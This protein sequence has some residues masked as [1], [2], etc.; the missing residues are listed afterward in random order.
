MVD[1]DKT[2]NVC[3][4][5]REDEPKV[6]GHWDSTINRCTKVEVTTNAEGDEV[7]IYPSRYPYCNLLGTA[8]QCSY[9]DGNGTE[10]RCILPDPFRHVC[11]RYTGQKWV[12]MRSPAQYDGTGDMLQA[13]DWSFDDI[14]GYNDGGCDG[15]GTDMEC[16]GYSPYHMGFGIIQPEGLPSNWLEFLE[17]P[18]EGYKTV[19]DLGY[20]LPILYVVLNV[21]AKLSRCHWWAGDIEEF[22]ID[23]DIGYVN[24][25]N[26]LCTCNDDNTTR[27]GE[28]HFDSSGRFIPPCNGAHD[29]CP[30]YT[31]ICW[32]HCIV[33]KMQTGDKILAEQILELRY[34]SKRET[35]TL[36]DYNELF[37]HPKIFSWTGPNG[38]HY[39]FTDAGI[40]DVDNTLID[41]MEV[42]QEDF[43]T[44]N[45]EYKK[46]P[47]SEGTPSQDGNMRFPTLVGSI[48][49]PYLKP[50]IRNSFDKDIYGNNLFEVTGLH[51]SSVLIYGDTFWYGSRTYAINLRDDDISKLIPS[52]IFEFEDMHE[53]EMT[54]STEGEEYFNEFYDQLDYIFT[55][56]ITYLPDKVFISEF[57]DN[58]SAFYIDFLANFG[59]NLVLVFN[60][61]SG[62]WEFD[63]M[64]FVKGLCGGVIKQHSFSIV[65]TDNKPAD[66]L[67]WY[68]RNFYSL[69]NENGAIDFEFQSF[70]PSIMVSGSAVDHVYNDHFT[71]VIA[72][73]PL[74]AAS[75]TTYHQSYR[76]FRVT[77]YE[78][79]II[80]KEHMKFL[81]SSGYVVVNV[82]D[83]DKKLSNVHRLWES[84]NGFYLLV[85]D[86]SGNSKRIKMEV[87]E[88][89]T[90]RLEVNQIVLKPENMNDFSQAC[91]AAIHTNKI[92][93]Y[94][95]R[96]FGETPD[97]E[98]YEDITEED[99]GSGANLVYWG[100]YQVLDYNEDTDLFTVSKFNSEPMFISVVYKG[101]NGRIKGVTRTKLLVWIKQPFCRDVEIYYKWAASYTKWLLKPTFNCLISKMDYIREERKTKTFA[102]PC[103]DHDLKV[104]AEPA[105][106]WY[107]YNAC[108]P[109]DR[110]EIITQFTEWD[111]S[112]IEQFD[113][114]SDDP[115]H[116]A[117]DMRMMG[118]FNSYAY[119]C[120]NHARLRN[121]N[122]D[123][124]YCNDIK[125][126]VDGNVFVGYGRYRGGLSGEAIGECTFNGGEMP[127]FGNVHRDF[128]RSYRSMD[129]VFYYALE[130][131]MNFVR[132]YKWMPMYEMYS[133]CDLTAS[134]DYYPY[135]LY[136][137]DYTSPFVN[138][139]SLLL[140]NSSIENV[141]INE[142]LDEDHRFRFEDVFEV[143]YS[144]ATLVYPY[145]RNVYYVG[146]SQKPLI[147]WY[148]FKEYVYDA[149]KSIQ[150]AWQEDWED[151][152]RFNLSDSDFMYNEDEDD[153][154][155]EDVY[156]L[157]YSF[158][159]GV[160]NGQHMFL[161]IE[162]PEYQ[163][164]AYLKEHRLVCEEGEHT[165][166]IVPCLPNKDGK[167]YFLLLLDNGPFRIF[168]LSGDWVTVDPGVEFGSGYDSNVINYINLY[169]SCDTEDW[170][171]E[172]TLYDESTPI[173][174]SE[175]ASKEAARD[176]ER[177]VETYDSSGLE[178]E[179]FYQRGLNV[180][181]N[182]SQF[183]K[184][185][186]KET[187]FNNGSADVA[188]S[189]VPTNDDSPYSS[190]EED[191]FV[192]MLNN[193][194]NVEYEESVN[195]FSITI[196]FEPNSSDECLKRVISKARICF[197]V[198]SEAPTG[199]TADLSDDAWNG[200]LYHIPAVSVYKGN[201]LTSFSQIH[202]TENMTLYS[203]ND[204]KTN[205]TN[206]Y[207]MDFS[208]SDMSSASRYVKFVFRVKPDSD[209]VE[210]SSMFE[211][212]SEAT[213]K[214]KLNFLDIFYVEFVEAEEPITTYERLYYVSYGSHGDFPPQG[215]DTSGALLYPIY[216]DGSTVY[217]Y[218]TIYGVAGLPGTT[219]ATTSMN[220]C[221]GRVMKECHPDKEP[222]PGRNV[223]KWESLQ[224]KVHD[225]IA[226]N[227]GNTV[228]NSK[229]TAPPN[230]LP[231]LAKAGAYFQP[232][233]CYFVNTILR[234]LASVLPRDTYSPCGHEYFHDTDTVDLDEWEDC[235][236]VMGRLWAN[237]R[238]YYGYRNACSG[239]SAMWHDLDVFTVYLRSSL[240][241]YF[242]NPFV[243][244]QA[245]AKRMAFLGDWEDNTTEET[246]DM[247][248]PKT[249]RP[250]I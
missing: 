166:K 116:G 8:S 81:G 2:K 36:D 179:T 100:N 132:E 89:G 180:S 218:D 94:Q 104:I 110:Y 184:L 7:L 19:D 178:V 155:I 106:M 171:E 39:A 205:E 127:K 237:D 145:P 150:W 62:R 27:F 98:E 192:A 129:N 87:Y 131:F 54:L 66:R 163:Y 164:D 28:A 162:Y 56:I 6:C 70:V 21:R 154:G 99:F 229:G 161:N 243:F 151:L 240:G 5:W 175:E 119:T 157:P 126:V 227:T 71:D 80:T 170:I 97:E 24:P 75:Y 115:E 114:Y 198:G 13:A 245:D 76:I 197:V 241:V 135:N 219:S 134:I 68:E 153:T 249:I 92:Y 101:A 140:F 217:Q 188:I 31:G 109:Y 105:P 133:K 169:D 108:P 225:D 214:V 120:D 122:C 25:T 228:I 121:C 1:R 143:A 208:Y 141:D 165:I 111:V 186:Y 73:N 196:D 195:S 234:P 63:K 86:V 232:W 244:K 206:V 185:P 174:T 156:N 191:E 90:S 117:F 142:Q 152:V 146:E 224:K 55:N 57:G 248:L 203:K 51:D 200:T 4:Y 148:R 107:P 230:M 182:A 42:Y 61:G 38:I 17:N 220:K 34:Y 10:A 183:D 221:R 95:K 65:S 207:E 16:S 211:Y 215:T 47:L 78:N 173:T 69:Q 213:N 209:E 238:F 14:T 160:V 118:P 201:S 149:G 59:D 103:G 18:W 15:A 49:S 147:S 136:T 3:Q 22:S 45:V 74:A 130:G 137:R 181:I 176:D 246:T 128:L 250:F 48:K 91:D 231:V 210:A 30:H 202:N 158:E 239:G 46:V 242:L 144:T 11:N 233:S 189:P 40:L 167:V 26:F 72:N 23:E 235:S 32:Q 33:D 194:F 60:K 9:Y 123:W 204:S 64:S 77:V 53:I 82:P 29:E 12:Y 172:V 83:P 187:L 79:V 35:W 58:S 139:I 193:V 113:I 41:S 168:D 96:S 216:G 138:Q 112:I 93:V 102:P 124:S 177:V 20:R 236:G 84:S 88:Q 44:F 67:P 159:G 85:T 223:Y 190:L 43:S 199:A 212:Y 50:I 52:E 226:L 247:A 222:L 125:E 37:T